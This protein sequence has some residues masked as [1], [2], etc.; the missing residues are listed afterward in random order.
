MQ[1]IQPIGANPLKKYFRQP[2]LYISLPSKGKWYPAGALELTESGEFPVY[3]MTAKDELSMKTPDALLNGESTVEVIKSCMP[4]I[5][6]PWKMPAI[7]I[8][9]VLIAIRMATYG[10][11]LDLDTRIPNTDIEKRF[12][13]DLKHLLE[14]MISN[15]YED[16]LYHQDLTI[17]VRPL[18]Y[19]EFTKNAIKTFEEQRIFR[20]VVSDEL[21]EEEKLK[22]F[23]QSFNKL[24]EITVSMVSQCIH[25]IDVDGETVKNPAFI[26]DF[27]DNADKDFFKAV[28]EHLEFQKDK[29]SVK[30]F[31]VIT[32]EQDREAGA[33]ESYT[34]PI[35]FDSANF[36]A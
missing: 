33:P 31:E 17:H 25:Q 32:D 12:S 18:N 16:V 3:S 19:Q 22:R 14:P 15:H 27:I 2:K 30:P 6:D 4:N 36:F 28:T 26:Q 29:F 24:T 13:V 35:S 21:T 5:R 9:A 34:I 7:D 8:E 20:A 23:H 1:E 10:D 11:Q